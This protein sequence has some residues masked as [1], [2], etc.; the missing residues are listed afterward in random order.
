MSEL[1][2]AEG[3]QIAPSTEQDCMIGTEMLGMMVACKI[4]KPLDEYVW[5]FKLVF[6]MTVYE[7]RV[8][9]H[10]VNEMTIRDVWKDL[11]TKAF[12]AHEIGKQNKGMMA[13]LAKSD[14]RAE[15]E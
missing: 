4:D 14:I 2:N 10:E 8:P 5:K 12:S 15:G 11:L 7:T 6:G 9:D 1:L 13:T 3:H